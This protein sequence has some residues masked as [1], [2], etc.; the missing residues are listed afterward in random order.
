MHAGAPVLAASTTALPEVVGDAGI[1]VDPDDAQEWSRQ[2]RTMIDK[3]DLRADLA[4]RGHTRVAT[5]SWQRTVDV[6]TDAYRRAISGVVP[7]AG[8]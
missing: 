5:F 1:L 8:G 7:E 4:A 3:P 6:I 2:M